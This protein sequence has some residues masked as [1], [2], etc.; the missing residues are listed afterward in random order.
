MKKFV[1]II[2][3][4]TLSVLLLKPILHKA[5]LPE[6]NSVVRFHIRAN[7]DSKDDQS[8]KLAVRDEIVCFAESVTKNCKS[9]GEA[10]TVLCENFNEMKLIADK[11]LKENGFDYKT[12]ISLT[13]EHFPEKIY[14]EVT[15]PEGI[16][17]AVRI[18]IG[19][20]KGENFWC[21][22]FPPICL[23]DSCTQKVLDEYGVDDFNSETKFTVK[24][25]LWETIKNL[26][27]KE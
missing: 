2:S 26:F 21:V 11:V 12:K 25:K 6:Y 5:P 7:S 24:F 10:S 18:D 1:L 16:Y 14:G 3:L 9:A 4:C 23:A 13:K 27:F 20:G 8:V 22:L 17:T 19:E 15:F